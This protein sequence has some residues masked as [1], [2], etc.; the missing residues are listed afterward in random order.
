MPFFIAGDCLDVLDQPCVEECQADCIYE[1]NRTM[2]INPIECIDRG[3][4]EPV[5]AVGADT[6]RAAS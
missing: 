2:Y 4:C 1:G 6:F 3:A 5:G